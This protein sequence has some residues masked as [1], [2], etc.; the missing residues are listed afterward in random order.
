MF[1]AELAG[2]VVVEHRCILYYGELFASCYKS[3]LQKQ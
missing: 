3:K 1:Q 2:V